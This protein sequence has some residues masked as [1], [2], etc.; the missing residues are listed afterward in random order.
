MQKAHVSFLWPIYLQLVNSPSMQTRP[1]A[2]K[3]LSDERRGLINAFTQLRECPGLIHGGLSG[4]EWFR[5]TGAEHTYRPQP[6]N[7]AG[8][9]SST[10]A[11]VINTHDLSRK[12]R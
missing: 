10:K 2:L 9:T 11:R 5:S 1:G 12:A 7:E 4:E 3:R 6:A 8:E